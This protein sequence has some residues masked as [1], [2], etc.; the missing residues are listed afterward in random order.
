MAITS[1]I[2][3]QIAK[4][5]RDRELNYKI[6]EM[7]RLRGFQ[8]LVAK[9]PSCLA[10]WNKNVIHSDKVAGTV[11]ALFSIFQIILDTKHLTFRVLFKSS[12]E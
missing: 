12:H 9:P 1:Q 7:S 11:R 5:Y 10:I 8:R 2:A 3:S 6:F 4:N